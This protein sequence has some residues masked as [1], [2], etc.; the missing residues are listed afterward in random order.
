MIIAEGKIVL[1]F[2][3]HDLEVD[4][5]S[6]WGVIDGLFPDG[7]QGELDVIKSNVNYEDDEELE[8]DD[9]DENLIY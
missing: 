9:I 3:F 7:W 5:H 2:N 1:E 6:V 8:D 4:E